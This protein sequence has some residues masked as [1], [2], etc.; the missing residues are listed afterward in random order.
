MRPVVLCCTWKHNGSDN[1]CSVLSCGASFPR[2]KFSS[3]RKV[4]GVRFF[5]ESFPPPTFPATPSKLIP[6]E[7]EVLH[8]RRDRRRRIQR[9]FLAATAVYLAAIAALAGYIGW[10][11]FQ[12]SQL[13]KQLATELP[14]VQ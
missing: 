14:T 11:K 3:W 7:V 6:D 4:W 9:L 13:R 10:Q 8:A 12:A 5:R 2:K 1:H